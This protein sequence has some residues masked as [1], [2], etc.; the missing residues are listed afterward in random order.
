MYK[1]KRKERDQLFGLLDKIIEEISSEKKETGMMTLFERYGLLLRLV[2]ENEGSDDEIE[3]ILTAFKKEIIFTSV[4]ERQYQGLI[5]IYNQYRDYKVTEGCYGTDDDVVKLICTE[6]AN[7]LS[8]I[9]NDHQ[10]NFLRLGVGVT[11]LYSNFNGG[12][13]LIYGDPKSKKI[14]EKFYTMINFLLVALGYAPAHRAFHVLKPDSESYIL[15]DDLK[16]RN[17]LPLDFYFYPIVE[18]NDFEM[19]IKNIHKNI[20]TRNQ[21]AEF[22]VFERILYS[23]RVYGNND[24]EVSNRV[25]QI[26]TLYLNKGY[27]K[28]RTLLKSLCEY[29]TDNIDMRLRAFNKHPEDITIEGFYCLL[30]DICY[31]M[32]DLIL[33]SRNAQNNAGQVLYQSDSNLRTISEELYEFGI[34]TLDVTEDHQTYSGLSLYASASE[35]EELSERDKF[36]DWVGSLVVEAAKFRTKLSPTPDKRAVS[37]SIKRASNPTIGLDWSDIVEINERNQFFLDNTGF[38]ERVLSDTADLLV[39]WLPEGFAKSA[40]L[41]ALYRYLSFSQKSYVKELYQDCSICHSVFQN[42]QGVFPVVYLD[43]STFT[44]SSLDG[45]LKSFYNRIYDEYIENVFDI[46]CHS[47]RQSPSKKSQ[48]EKYGLTSEEVDILFNIN[49]RKV[50]K[51]NK[52]KWLEIYCKF[53]KCKSN[54]TVYIIIDAVD[55]IDSD[56]SKCG[57]I[58]PK[59]DF[60]NKM[61]AFIRNQ[62]YENFRIVASA[63]QPSILE[64]DIFSEFDRTTM[65]YMTETM[66]ANDFCFSQAQVQKMMRETLPNV[67]LEIDPVSERFT[68]VKV[69]SPYNLQEEM[70]IPKQIVEELV[71]QYHHMPRMLPLPSA[72]E[73]RHVDGGIV[74]IKRLP[75]ST[76]VRQQADVSIYV[77]DHL[78][79]NIES[80]RG[81]KN[82]VARSQT[83]DNGEALVDLCHKGATK[84]QIPSADDTCDE[85][86]KAGTA[87]LHQAN[88]SPVTESPFWRKCEDDAAEANHE[89]S[90]I[91]D[92][93][94]RGLKIETPEQRLVV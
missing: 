91:E 94:T 22:G 25:N 11:P 77:P 71:C 20:T 58:R 30:M 39:F 49:T 53:L 60:I 5:K 80:R 2:A 55:F 74:S 72:E 8:N 23:N 75:N 85:R 56:E 19:Y 63:R 1:F 31:L 68:G 79:A 24:G 59:V 37:P 28:E 34:K 46:E 81:I 3:K 4:S 29:H 44:E 26:R 27:P 40:N 48:Y 15:L 93:T 35:L 45:V 76:D 9:L 14:A 57:D 70:Y 87:L 88:Q 16:P 65:S 92:K 86:A 51:E 47:D 50:S 21:W 90:A 64:L 18:I 73:R 82:L 36:L 83:T 42:V 67:D 41:Q 66:Y 12:Y 10:L 78:K 32:Y 43:F 33:L 7:L 13:T 89:Q 17:Y 62:N 52:I 69:C 6:L 84:S 61:L 38:I 54:K